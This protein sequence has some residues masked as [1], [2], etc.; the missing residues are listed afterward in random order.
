MESESKIV[1]LIE[2]YLPLADLISFEYSNVPGSQVGDARSEA[3]LALIASAKV[4]D[5][6]RGEFVSLASRAIRNRL[7]TFYAKQL[8]MAKLFPESLDAPVQWNGAPN[9][10][11]SC[12]HLMEAADPKTDLIREVRQAESN[13]ALADVM[14][15]LTPREQ[16]M[17]GALAQGFSFA[18]IA[19][20]HAISKQAAHKA[21]TSALSKLRK[22]LQMLGYRGLASDGHLAS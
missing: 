13:K 3:H 2:E 21:I 10:E 9:Q 6:K 1:Q 4:F 18:E 7:N 16:Q 8:R 15:F 19:E 20:S 22:S 11:A 5:P 12:E 17:I 14:K